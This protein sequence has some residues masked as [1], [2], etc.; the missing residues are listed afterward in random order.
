VYE[1]FQALRMIHIGFGTVALVVFWVPI[2]AP[3]GGKL[4]VRI[5]W[6][7]VVC[8]SVVVLTAFTMSGLAYRFP[9]EV[10]H[11]NHVLSAAE[12]VNYTEAAHRFATFLAFLGGV[13]LA[14]GWQ[15]I[16]VLRTRK[17][18]NGLRNPF[19]LALN[20]AIVLAA[21]AVLSMGLHTNNW[22]FIG[23]SAVGLVSAGNL[24]YLMRKPQTKMHWW[25]EHVSSMIATAIAGYT[26]FLVFGGARLMPGLAASRYYVVIWL[27]PTAI[28]TPAIALTIAYYRR[29][30]HD[31]VKPLASERADA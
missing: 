10:R 21:I 29:K 8:M 5:G 11:F 30:F 6:T 12:A 2:A 15:G 25:Y 4:H 13:T 7:Y 3:K 17:N 1:L 14:A 24:A 9:L 20:A 31:N 16:G 28:G 19:T 22:T 26:A 18:P 27:L 23:M